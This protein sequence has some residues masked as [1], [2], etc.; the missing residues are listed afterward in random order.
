M[1]KNDL[2]LLSDYLADDLQESDREAVD[3]RLAHDAAFAAL[4]RNRKAEL[5]ALK[6]IARAE[7]KAAL[8]A[9]FAQQQAH[10]QAAAPRKLWTLGAV[11]VAA[12]IALLVLFR[13][14]PWEAAPS[15]RE[16]ALSYLEPFP[17][18]VDRGLTDTERPTWDAA[19]QAYQAGEFETALPLLRR[20]HTTHP[21]DLLIALALAECLSQT[22]SFTEAAT[23]L[24]PLATDSPFQD[25]A[26]WRL[27]LNYLLAG[28]EASARP[29]LEAIANGPHYRQ[30]AADTLLKGMENQ[31]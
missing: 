7:T 11:S 19:S 10:Q 2:H 4:Y 25:A 24:L 1:E 27:A 26:Q 12:A 20:L 13:L 30:A 21:D 15:P 22:G 8:K 31:P 29:L 14:A 6:A 3:Q 5:N 16:L 23:L 17:L 28:N 18:T 9:Q